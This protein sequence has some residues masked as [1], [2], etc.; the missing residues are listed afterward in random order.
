[1]EMD[2]VTNSLLKKFRRMQSLPELIDSA[3]L[4][5]HFVNYCIL[6]EIL[7]EEFSPIEVSTGGGGD[8]G[9]DG[10]AIV[11][12]SELVQDVEAVEQLLKANRYL[13]VKFVFAQAKS[14]STFRGEALTSFADGVCDFFGSVEPTGMSAGVRDRRAVMEYIYENSDAFRTGNPR[15]E[16][17]YATTGV[18]KGDQNLLRR[19]TRAQERLSGL[20][21]FSEVTFRPV[22]AKELQDLW[23]RSTNAAT[24]EFEFR[25]KQTL[26]AMAGVAEA[27]LGL[28]PYEEFLK[29]IAD[30]DSLR[31]GIFLAN[32]R[33]FQGD[34]KVNSKIA[35]SLA[36]A[37]GRERF[38]VLNNGITIVTRELSTVSDKFT[39][40]D[41]QIVNGCQTSHVLF[42]ARKLP[43]LDFEVPVK[44]VSTVDEDVISAIAE[45]TNS[46]TSVKDEDLW[47]LEGIHKHIEQL[48][49]SYEGKGALFYERR[50]KQYASDPSVEKVRIIT[51]G[52]LARAFVAMFRNDAHR[53]TRYYSSLRGSAGE[54]FFAANHQLAPYYSAAFA[55]YR[56][57][58]FFRNGIVDVRLKP[59]RFQLLLLFRILVAGWDMPEIAANGIVRYCRKLDECLLDDKRSTLIFKSAESLIDAAVSSLD[60]VL[61]GE[62]TKRREFTDEVVRLA[63]ELAADSE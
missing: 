14:A 9:I 10:L 60:E 57:E 1:M 4:F 52:T 42:R 43:D 12:N 47:A 63:R 29:L 46:Q 54:Q 45:A 48:F 22:G 33:D 21:L 37:D 23:R 36:T 32:V 8:M 61:N 7:D 13:D 26:A 53:A 49:A 28:V 56:L 6:A 31:S 51:K 39:L 40:T 41:Y 5:E 62:L 58:Y 11:V 34:N 16:L 50:S 3:T 2:R 17:V 25:K 44:V 30:G 18:W 19:V 20:N 59:A 35:A 24:A 27:Y 15:C 38:G 55:H